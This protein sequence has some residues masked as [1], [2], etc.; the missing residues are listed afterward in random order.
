[1]L[2]TKPRVHEGTCDAGFVSYHELSMD[3]SGWHH[4][5]VVLLPGA[6]FSQPS[7]WPVS[8]RYAS[9]LSAYIVEK[10]EV[11]NQKQEET[12]EEHTNK[13][14]VLL[15]HHKKESQ[16]STLHTNTIGRDM[17]KYH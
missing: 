17:G 3:P 1:M 7:A 9:A 13:A 6:V 11:S 14:T 8:A 16:V 15:P 2:K 5:S 4:C 10:Q 12:K